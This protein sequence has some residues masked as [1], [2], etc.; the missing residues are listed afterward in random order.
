MVEHKTENKQPENLPFEVHKGISTSIEADN[1]SVTGQRTNCE[2]SAKYRVPTLP[3]PAALSSYSTL[4]GID[5]PLLKR[6]E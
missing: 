6:L 4:P 3:L 5:T 1:A 2:P